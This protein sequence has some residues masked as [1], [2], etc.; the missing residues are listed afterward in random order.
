MISKSPKVVFDC[1]MF[2]QAA[3]NPSG[4]AAACLRVLE[5]QLIRVLVTREI[6]EE[7][8]Q[9]LRKPLI[10]T[11]YPRLTETV[12]L[13]FIER[14]IELVEIRPPVAKRFTYIRDPKD[15]PYINLAI[16]EDANYLVSRDR[17]LLD[18]AKIDY[19]D[20][21]LLRREAPNLN[22]LEPIEFLNT[23]RDNLRLRE[24]FGQ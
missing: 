5:N 4:P 8:E 1:M 18:L 15:E 16:A 17:D 21:A 14:I 23:I 9:T 12:I 7:I 11:S 3:L 22:I 2:L 24:Q 10:Q 20:A 13:E 6:L 19:P